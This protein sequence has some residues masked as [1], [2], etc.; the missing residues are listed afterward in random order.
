MKN[1]P[2]SKIETALE[3]IA[4]HGTVRTPAIAE[5]L[6]MPERNVRPMLDPALSNGYLVSCQVEV[7]Q[8]DGKMRKMMEYRVSEIAAESKAS[9]REFTLGHAPARNAREL[10]APKA[11]PPRTTTAP[12]P[13]VS[14]PI[15]PEKAAPA[16]LAPESPFVDPLPPVK[17]ET[18]ESLFSIGS[19]KRLRITASGVEIEL[20]PEETKTLGHLMVGSMEIWRHRDYPFPA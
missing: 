15:A 8:G 1:K 19:D 10:Q 13:A 18:P 20:S 12:E 6:E 14:R 3:Y 2:K 11:P 17:T 16:A 5:A 7:R 4:K 9:W